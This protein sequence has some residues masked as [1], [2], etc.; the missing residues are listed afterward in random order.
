MEMELQLL[1]AASWAA[2]KRKASPYVDKVERFGYHQQLFETL[3]EAKGYSWLR[4]MGHAKI[5]FLSERRVPTPDLIGLGPAPVTLV[6][7]KTINE[8]RGQRQ[9]FETP[10]KIRD[11]VEVQTTVP[12]ALKRE[13]LRTVTTARAQLRAF[14]ERPDAG[15]AVYLVIRPDFDFQADEEL[16]EFI[17]SLNSTDVR[18]ALEIL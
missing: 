7:V 12:E 6:E 13:I 3:H 4:E 8:S 1:D 17:R 11:L 16:L 9:Y 2:L 10:A 18:V 5:E 15:R 14:T